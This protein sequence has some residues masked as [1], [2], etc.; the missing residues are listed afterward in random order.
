MTAHTARPASRVFRSEWRKLVALRV[1]GLG[2]AVIIGISLAVGIGVAA[3]SDPGAI[4][5]AQENRQYPV[6]F[7]ASTIATWGFAFLAASFVAAEF[8]GAGQWTFVATPRRLRVLSAKRRDRRDDRDAP[9]RSGRPHRATPSPGHSGE[10][11][12]RSDGNPRFRP[13]RADHD[14]AARGR[15]RRRLR[16]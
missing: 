10:S 11:P 2:A 4:A 3:V 6:I 5:E 8:D 13:P 16:Q 15:P 7:Y 14:H 1:T 12:R 9:A